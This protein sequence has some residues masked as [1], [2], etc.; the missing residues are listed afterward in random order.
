MKLTSKQ[1]KRIIKEELNKITNE[2]KVS[3]M[4]TKSGPATLVEDSPSNLADNATRY[5]KKFIEEAEEDG[6]TDELVA[7]Y[8]F[9]G[10][11][12]VEN[13]IMYLTKKLPYIVQLYKGMTQEKDMEDALNLYKVFDPSEEDDE[14]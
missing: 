6:V 7:T 5:L 3:H 12:H 13:Y 8:F 11:N 4:R 9:Q 14:E 10:P 1:L 2:S